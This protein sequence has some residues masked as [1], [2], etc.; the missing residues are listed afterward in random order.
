VLARV[1]PAARRCARFEVDVAQRLAAVGSPVAAPETP[2]VF[3]RG[4]YV[5]TRWPTTNR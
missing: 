3:V 4:D 5:I 2:E 1:A